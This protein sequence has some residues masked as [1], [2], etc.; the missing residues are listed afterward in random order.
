MPLKKSKGRKQGISNPATSDPIKEKMLATLRSHWDMGLEITE[1]KVSIRDFAKEKGIPERTARARRAFY[2]AYRSVNKL[3]KL[4]ALRRK[5]TDRPLNSG[6]VGYLLTI[7][8]S[9]TDFGD[10]TTD[11][12][13]AFAKHAAKNDLSPAQLHTFIRSKCDRSNASHGR[14]IVP[15]NTASAVENVARDAVNWIK[16]CDVTIDFIQSDT[17][18]S[19][20][21]VA[22]LEEF[23]KWTSYAARLC[24]VPRG[25][26]KKVESLERSMESSRQKMLD[27]LSS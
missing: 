5:V 23:S 1:R 14:A 7:K 9:V 20:T 27:V 18:T 26:E 3:N 8:G 15:R 12:R 21:L 13:N 10:N 19:K 22:L 17:K 4:C 25:D 6:H 16:R 11:A 2:L 24:D